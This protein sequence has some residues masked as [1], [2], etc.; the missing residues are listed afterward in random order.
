M[1]CY[2]SYGVYNS[3]DFCLVKF[4]IITH[5]YNC[6][7]LLLTNTFISTYG[8]KYVLLS[9]FYMTGGVFHYLASPSEFSICLL[10]TCYFTCYL[11]FF[12]YFPLVNI[13]LCSLE[14]LLRAEGDSLFQVVLLFFFNSP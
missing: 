13:F 10:L 7:S 12:F 6:S 14:H 3:T 8:Y 4:F 2:N 5:S 9:I 11:L 1:E